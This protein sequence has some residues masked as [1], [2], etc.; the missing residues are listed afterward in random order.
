MELTET[1]DELKTLV[2]SFQTNNDAAEKAGEEKDAVHKEQQ[3][4]INNR[5][6][7]LEKMI[8]K[9]NFGADHQKAVE[10][11]ENQKFNKAFVDIVKFGDK[12][13]KDSWDL[14]KDL[15][16]KTM[17]VGD[18]TTGGIWAPPEMLNEMIKNIVEISPFRQVATVRNTSRRSITI[19]VRSRTAS[20]AWVAEQGNQD[21]TQNPLFSMVEIPTHKLYARA[22]ITDEDLEDPEFNIVN[23]LMTE[24][25]EQFAL[26]EGQA[27]INGD[28]IEKPEGILFDSAKNQSIASGS[29]TLLTADGVIDTMYKG[30][31]SAYWNRTTWIAN[32]RTIGDI[33]K[34]KD[35]TGRYIFDAG[36]DAS[37]SPLAQSTPG[38]LLGRPMVEMPDM[39]DVAADATPLALGDWK[40]S[41]YIADRVQT[42]ILRDI[43]TSA[44]QGV[45]RIFARKRL[46][47]QPVKRESYVLNKVE[48]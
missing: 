44:G 38:T 18:D 22:D 26:T 28:G 15:K 19:P 24:F 6:C 43:Y 7:D 40:A 33:R 35:S 9:P 23:F 31:K 34:F 46:G 41:Y 5:L 42:S 47:G 11:E 32:R 20:A 30:L 29:G 48:S 27:M 4:K 16:K 3:E 10:N 13:E 17:I 45:V 39:P 25:N 12:A 36:Y 21:E 8:N 37:P 2:K 1:I 14:F